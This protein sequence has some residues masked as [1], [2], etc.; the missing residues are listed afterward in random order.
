M[1]NKKET[2]LQIMKPEIPDYYASQFMML[3]NGIDVTVM[4]SSLTPSVSVAPN[5]NI[6]TNATGTEIFS[7]PLCMVKMSP[8][9][10]KDLYAVLGRTLEKLE[11][12]FG[13]IKTPNSEAKKQA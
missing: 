12:D 6:D 13:P 7:Q 5:G 2:T 9:T 11:K 8:G 10:A 3:A 4:F 1:I